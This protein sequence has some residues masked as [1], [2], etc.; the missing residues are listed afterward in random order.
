M[1]GHDVLFLYLFQRMKWRRRRP[2]WQT[3]GRGKHPGEAIRTNEKRKKCTLMIVS[4]MKNDDKTR[5]IMVSERLLQIADQWRESVETHCQ[6]TLTVFL[7]LHME[8]FS[9]D[10]ISISWSNSS[11]SL[12]QS[13]FSWSFKSKFWAL[14]I[15]S[16]RQ[17]VHVQDSTIENVIF[18]DDIIQNRSQ[19]TLTTFSPHRMLSDVGN[20]NI[21]S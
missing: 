7:L 12:Y 6:K 14:Q 18:L 5:H 2:D 16:A 4:A 21:S 1:S 8:L 13:S 20:R 15:Y 3:D 10:I 17:I 9:L 19:I 11:F